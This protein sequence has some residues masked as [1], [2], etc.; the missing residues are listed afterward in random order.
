MRPHAFFRYL[1]VALGQTGLTEF[2]LGSFFVLIMKRK[3]ISW[4]KTLIPLKCLSQLAF[5]LMPYFLQ[6]MPRLPKNALFVSL[7]KYVQ[8]E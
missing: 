1:E 7:L 5:S 4:L 6:G 2:S 8:R 3:H